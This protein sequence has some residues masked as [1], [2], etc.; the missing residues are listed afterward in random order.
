MQRNLKP[1]DEIAIR[2]EQ[3]DAIANLRRELVI[4]Y[5]TPRSYYNL[6]AACLA[7]LETFKD[8]LKD[9]YQGCTD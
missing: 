3:C 9:M 8:D 7:L 4:D 5:P 6:R 1:Q 2:P